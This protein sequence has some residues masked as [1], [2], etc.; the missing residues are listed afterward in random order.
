M[1]KNWHPI[2]ESETTGIPPKLPEVPTDRSL[3]KSDIDRANGLQ[4]WICPRCQHVY[5]PFT[6]ECSNCNKSEFL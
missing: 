1:N 4:G 6:Q 3:R 2:D 5:S